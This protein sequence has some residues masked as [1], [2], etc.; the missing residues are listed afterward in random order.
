MSR[1]KFRFPTITAIVIANMVG[2][3][4]FTSLGFQL[5]DI[6]SGFVILMLWAIGGV[7]AVSGAMTYAELGAAFPRSGGEYNFLSRVYHPAVGF[8]AGWTSVTIGFAGPSALAAMTFA[9]YATSILEVTPSVWLERA[10][11]VGLVLVLTIVHAG[12]RR[13]SGGVQ[14]IFTTLKV[15]VIVG[16]CLGAFLLI[17]E[18]Q[19]VR[20]LPSAGDSTLFTGS[21]FAISLIYVSYAYTGWNAAT[22]LSSELE[23]PQRTLPAIL[24]TGTL[25][26]TLLYVALNFIFLYA[27]PIAELQGQV[28]VGL[29][30][31]KAAFGEAGGRFTGLVLAMLLISTVSAML[32]AGPRVLQ[33]MGQDF[34]MLRFTAR[35][36]EDGIPNTAIYI[37]S[38]LAVLFILTSSFESVLLFA[39]FTLALNSFVTVF[40]VFVLRWRQPELER[41][42][43][44]FLYPL[45]PLIYLT[46]M[47]WTLWFVLVNRPVEGLFGLGVIASGLV[48]YWLLSNRSS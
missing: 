29:I 28:E 34:R 24:L 37:Q 17:D 6:Q 31:A 45:P 13:N 33:V 25:V 23:N 46:L 8:V 44:T 48:V 39:G 18:P 19:P 3:G 14:V 12:K 27:A 16:F 21:A 47:G 35:V 43:R 30:A 4:V 11:A 40:G 10:L 20:F 41:P 32:M 38:A 36:N 15:A 26:V 2:T 1:D 9:A 22:Y 7:I 5:L 42:Y